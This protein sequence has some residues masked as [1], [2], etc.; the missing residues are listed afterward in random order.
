V[1]NYELKMALTSPATNFLNFGTACSEERD[2]TIE[3]YNGARTQDLPT[4]FPSYL[5]S[6][7]AWFAAQ[8]PDEQHYVY[9][10]TTEDKLE[11][12]A[13]LQSF[14][15]VYTSSSFAPELLF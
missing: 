4:G 1:G 14:Q 13:A 15:G 2:Q 11:I 10:L 12:D 9:H 8:F 5:Y 7:L 6:D 3:T